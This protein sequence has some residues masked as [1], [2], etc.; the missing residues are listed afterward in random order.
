[1]PSS[2][3]LRKNCTFVTVPSLSA[4][5]A[6]SAIVAGAANEAFAAGAV[7]VTVG[8][9]LT[10]TVTAGDVVTAPLS[11]VAFAVMLYVPPATLAQECA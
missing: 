6:L 1:M 10:F 8:R 9:L 7:R 3:P 5:V 11:S 4:A 2:T